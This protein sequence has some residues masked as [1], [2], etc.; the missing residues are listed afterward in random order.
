MIIFHD[1]FKNIS[2]FLEIFLIN[3][4]IKF[5]MHLCFS[6]ESFSFFNV[7]DLANDPI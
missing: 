1:F 4:L 3:E 7:K 5:F 6:S 2:H